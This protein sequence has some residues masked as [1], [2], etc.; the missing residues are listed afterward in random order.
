MTYPGVPCVY[1]GDEIGLPGGVD[2]DNRRPMPWNEASWDLDLL[3]Y[4]KTFIAL[5]RNNPALKTGGFQMLYAEG[6]TY[7]FGRQSPE[8]HIV[9][10]AHR[11]DGPY[12]AF[13]LLARGEYR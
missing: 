5:R 10:I 12:K 9:V 8:Q 2:P 11:G 6:N 1:Y 13:Q 3:A 4:Y 7:A